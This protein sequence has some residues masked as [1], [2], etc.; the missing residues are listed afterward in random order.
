MLLVMIHGLL[1]VIV[2][3]TRFLRARLRTRLQEVSW[4]LPYKMPPPVFQGSFY[5]YGA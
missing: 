2:F 4:I 1:I 5:D 3:L